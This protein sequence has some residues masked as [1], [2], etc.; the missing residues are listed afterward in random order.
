M[1]YSK[2]NWKY[3]EIKILF[4]IWNLFGSRHSL[5]VP[6][7]EPL[8]SGGAWAGWGGGL[9]C[10]LPSVS[11]SKGGLKEIFACLI[12]VCVG[13]EAEVDGFSMV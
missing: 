5:S 13:G 4:D 3:S 9:I 12:W 2:E 8:S 1:L 6:G 10:W 7:E 11:L